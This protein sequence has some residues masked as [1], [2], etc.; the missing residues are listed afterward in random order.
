[1]NVNVAICVPCDAGPPWC[2]YAEARTSVCVCRFRFAL[3]LAACGPRCDAMEAKEE[4]AKRHHVCWPS[5]K[6]KNHH[7]HKGKRVCVGGGV[8]VWALAV[9]FS[10][11]PFSPCLGKTWLK[12]GPITLGLHWQCGGCDEHTCRR[13]MH[14]HTR[15]HAHA[16][17]HA[18]T[19]THTR[20]H[21]HTHAH[22]HTLSLPVC[23]FATMASLHTTIRGV[24]GRRALCV[25][26]PSEQAPLI[27]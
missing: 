14:S 18:H 2:S 9:F 23:T 16:R 13:D 5:R 20:T 8:Y 24:D 17:T 15:M 12:R 21:T 25:Q 7:M 6:W 26:T 3:I 1:M 4:P 10:S 19:R 27:S 22:T 11:L